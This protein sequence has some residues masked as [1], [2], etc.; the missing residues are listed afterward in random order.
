MALSEDLSPSLKT[1]LYNSNLEDFSWMMEIHS[2]MIVSIV[3]PALISC[4][5]R[6]CE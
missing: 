2:E 5:N 4:H 6:T 3:C 1:V